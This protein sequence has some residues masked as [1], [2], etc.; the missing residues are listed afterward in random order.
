M[1]TPA[2]KT[3]EQIDLR[4]AREAPCTD[5][6]NAERFRD[7]NRG[8]FIYTAAFG[9]FWRDGQ[10]WSREGV[11]HKV[12]IAEHDCVRAIADEAR[13]LRGGKYDAVIGRGCAGKII[14]RSDELLGWWLTSQAASKMEAIA[15]CA[16]PYLTLK[17]TNLDMLI[18]PA[19]DQ[20]HSLVYGRLPRGEVR[21]RKSRRNASRG[22]DFDD[23]L[24]GVRL[25]THDVT[26]DQE[27]PA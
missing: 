21:L 24:R 14:R 3:L 27:S 15:R 26:V 22:A 6:G 10:R 17:P 13:A 23:V 20:R 12:K 7:R 25:L 2:G 5:L 16:A 1:I 9:W 8:R 18:G 11:D 4:L 19:E